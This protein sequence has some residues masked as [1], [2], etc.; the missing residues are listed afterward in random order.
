MNNVWLGVETYVAD[1][2]NKKIV[3]IG[4][5][6][7]NELLKKLKEEAEERKRVAKICEEVDNGR[8]I[9]LTWQIYI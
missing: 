7:K 2:E 4:N 3:V 9:Y 1:V 8:S 6:N 5:F